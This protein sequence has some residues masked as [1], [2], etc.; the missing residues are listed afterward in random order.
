[1]PR[2]P[3]PGPHPLPPDDLR[4]RDLPI[5]PIAG[6]LHRVHRATR[7]P[8]FF[9]K[10]GE[11][12]FD[13]PA[14]A[15]GVLY[16]GESEACAFIETFGEPLDAPFVTVAQLTGRKLSTVE[17]LEPLRLVSLAGGD[18]RR[19]G[20][21]ARL[22][23]ADHEVAQAW[24]RA[25]HDHPSRPDGLRYPARH[26]PGELAVGVFD[27]AKPR[28]QAR[29]AEHTLGDPEAQKLVARLLDK[30]GLGLV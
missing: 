23:A 13:D 30:Y 19:I 3:R 4:D 22:F 24:A 29:V 21:D 15:F 5:V 27:R 1:V 26:D 10:T 7:A 12:R 2:S 9:G 14:H 8:L 28:L 11:N 18:L 17:V 25:L 20:A 16:V 6:P